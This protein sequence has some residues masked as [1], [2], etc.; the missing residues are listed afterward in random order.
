MRS[1][2][3]VAREF[4]K[5]YPDFA[6]T[7]QSKFDGDLREQL[8]LWGYNDNEE[9]SKTIDKECD[10][11]VRNMDI[12]ARCETLINPLSRGLEIPED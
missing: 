2:D 6:E 8:E 5:S 10:F 1:E 4:F 7:V 9:L 11:D 12:Q 3:S